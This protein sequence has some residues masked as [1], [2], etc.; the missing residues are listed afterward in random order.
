VR[1]DP[2]KIRPGLRAAGTLG[3]LL[4]ATSASG[5]ATK[6]GDRAG[7]PAKTST[8]LARY[9][10]AEGL[11]FYAEFQGL[12]AHS[13]GWQKTALSKVLNDT[14]LG[15][16]LA[17]LVSQGVDAARNAGGKGGPDGDRVVANVK[18]FLRKGAVAAVRRREG[19]GEK[20]DRIFAFRGGASR[21]TRGLLDAMA[22]RMGRPSGAKKDSRRGTRKLTMYGDGETAVAI[23]DEKGD[24]ILCNAEAVDAVIAA[25]EGKGANAEKNATRSELAREGDGF[26]PIAV[27]FLDM[28]KLPPMPPEA[29]RLG[30]KGLKRVDVRFG[31]QDDALMTVTQLVAPSPR[32]GL[33]ALLDQP[34]FEL[35]TLPPLPAESTDFTV[36]S[37]DPIKTYDRVVA[38]VEASDPA[39]GKSRVQAAERDMKTYLGT[40]LRRDLLPHLGP[41]F[42][43]FS[44]KPSGAAGK[45]PG[46][47]M[48]DGVVLRTQV[49][50]QKAVAGVID[51]LSLKL[52]KTLAEEMAAGALK[53]GGGRPEVRKVDG[54]KPAWTM[55]FPPG[56][57]PPNVVP[58]LVVG[59]DSMALGV[60]PESAEKGAGAIGTWTPKGDFTALGL[61][62]PRRMV[63]LNVN[64]PRQ[65]FPAMIEN[66]PT[67][68]RLAEA[69]M[70]QGA[71]AASPNA[72]APRI[73]IRVDPALIPKAEELSRRMGPG[74]LALTVDPSGIRVVNREEFPN[75]FSPAS[76]GVAVALLLPAVQ[77]AREAARRAQCVNNEK[78]MMLAFHNF[79]DTNGH[80]PRAAIVDKAGK[81]LLS[82][83]VAIL[84]YIEQNGLY[85]KFHLDEAWDS[86][87]NKALLDSM[88]PI[89]RCPS[90][91]ATDKTLA[92]Y[93]VFSGKG[94]MFE[95]GV[96]V[97]LN[98]II[99]GT[100]NTLALAET[101]VG[102]P[103]TK[104][105][106][107]DFD[108]AEKNPPMSFVVGSMH[109]G[110]FNAGMA[111]GSIRFFKATMKPELMKALI[112]RG[113]GEAIA[114]LNDF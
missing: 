109:P 50:D 43:I 22:A 64:D 45:T 70:A 95:P 15:A 88:P 83:R 60:S 58:T 87:H 89:Y 66:L 67:M 5:Q 44:G 96:D 39:N 57:V 71:R 114:P 100:S 91:P 2:S 32:K 31:F 27:A 108:P 48:V 61:R 34:T 74:S 46:I 76:A 18:L 25:I 30:L 84:P 49:D 56:R 82:W 6:P 21:E 55:T 107:L 105:E 75:L 13:R 85:E 37:L 77:S 23:W 36:L 113:G 14:K 103:W 35:G 54:P 47:Q 65:T 62:L 94:A 26:E 1:R 98:D 53:A 38:L 9:V 11:A 92:Y 63:L 4:L 79:A 8:S 90:I 59:K 99:D 40:D 102:V 41:K 86:P 3:L 68:M 52:K 28:S 20:F 7:S 104:P 19:G 78:Q 72:P 97:K 17:D 42:S 24:T 106:D 51:G 12:D 73:P 110:G 111:D 10:P 29:E 112:T 81:P 93:R 101:K 80:F 16:L 33:L 69:G